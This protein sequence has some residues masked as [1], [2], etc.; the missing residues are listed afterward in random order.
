M[1]SLDMK[2]HPTVTLER[3]TN[4]VERQRTSLDDPGFCAACGAEAGGVEPDTRR[5]ECEG[6]GVHAVYGAEELLIRLF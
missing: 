3:I 2:I 1:R 6:C 5:Y 4:A